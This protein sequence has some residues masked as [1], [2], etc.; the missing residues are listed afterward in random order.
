MNDKN[1]REIKDRNKI[2]LDYIS[3]STILCKIDNNYYYYNTMDKKRENFQENFNLYSIDGSR[4]LKSLINL[5]KNY[6]EF[7]YSLE[8]Q[9]N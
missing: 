5:N 3:N 9:E 1:N 7:L 8:R 2:N 6:E 4:N